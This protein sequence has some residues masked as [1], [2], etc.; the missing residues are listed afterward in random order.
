MSKA[1]KAMDDHEEVVDHR[2]HAPGITQIRDGKR[3][4]RGLIRE[5]SQSES[6][7]DAVQDW[8]GWSWKIKGAPNGFIS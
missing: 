2:M 7:E 3:Y 8:E 4:H 5:S 6:L 1:N